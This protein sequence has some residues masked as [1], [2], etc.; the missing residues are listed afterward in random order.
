[1]DRRKH[2]GK[3]SLLVDLS[4]HAANL[5]STTRRSAQRLPDRAPPAALLDE[6]EAEFARFD[7]HPDTAAAFAA[8][9]TRARALAAASGGG[10][11]ALR[12]AALVYAAD[13][14]TGLKLERALPHRTV[15][16]IVST[17]AAT[18]GCSTEAASLDLFLRAASN[19]RLLELPPLVAVELQV[20]LLLSLAPV[21][22]VSLWSHGSLGEVQ[23]LVHDGDAQPTR[24][25]RHVA[26]AALDGDADG[27]VSERGWIH[28]VPVKRWQQ[29]Y[30]ALVVRARPDCRQRALVFLEEAAALLA[31]VLERSMLLERNAERERALVES[32]ERRLVRLGFDLH[33]GPI[34]DLV[35]LATDVR[36]A[37]TQ[38]AEHV[39]GPAREVVAGRLEDLTAQIVELDRTLRE[40]AQSL[41]PARLFESSLQDVLQ[42][43]VESF[44]SRTQTQARLHLSGDMNSMTASQRIALYRIVQES[45][46]NVREHSGANE[47]QIRVQGSIRGTEVQIEDDGRGFEVANTLIS[48]AKRGRLGLVGMAERVRLLGG[49][50]D[51][52]SRPGGPTTVSLLL[53]HWQPVAP[54]GAEPDLA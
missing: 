47:V 46:T 32:S 12:S 1:M 50:F 23:C 36:Q 45:L 15:A 54:E 26:R 51:V 22:D 29:P 20:G 6:L 35:A 24:R 5:A 25:V 3:G 13:A 21:S 33:D 8:A 38:L 49:S 7:G 53:P 43:E 52:Q 40:V 39:D 48:A 19:P 14:L 27:G 34:Q 41:E 17:V 4:A 16:E 37:G 9:G 10:S 28:S 18:V 11:E 44:Q 42:R 30:A 2:E 31:P